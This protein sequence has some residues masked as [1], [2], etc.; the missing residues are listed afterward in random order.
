MQNAVLHAFEGR[1]QG[2]IR[3]SAN[4]NH[5]MVEVCCEDDGRGMPAEVLNHIFEPFFTTRLGKGGSG[6]GLSV[7]RNIALGVLGGTL[8]ASS[9]PEMGTCFV[10]TFPA[11]APH[12]A[13]VA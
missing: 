2:H 4:I 3:L 6:L 10:L 9:I 7:S 1:E 11:V 12:P 13:H 8:T 5:G